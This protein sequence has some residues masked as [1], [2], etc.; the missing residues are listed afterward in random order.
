MGI[1]GVT[2]TAARL[3]V[4]GQVWL[5]EEK[6][7]RTAGRTLLT[8]FRVESQSPRV[9]EIIKAA[10]GSLQPELLRI[11]MIGERVEDIFDPFMEEWTGS[12]LITKCDRV[13]VIRRWDPNGNN[14]K[15]SYINNPDIPCTYPMCLCSQSGLFEFIILDCLKEGELGTFTMSITGAHNT[16]ALDTN[17]R[18][19]LKVLDQ[20]TGVPC[21][22]RRKVEEKS[23][24]GGGKVKVGIPYVQPAAGHVRQRLK[25]LSQN[26]LGTSLPEEVPGDMPALPNAGECPPVPQPPVP[27]PPASPPKVPSSPPPKAKARVKPKAKPQSTPKNPPPS[28]DE[29]IESE[30]ATQ[31][32][33]LDVP[34]TSAG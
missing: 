7:E 28:L 24:T 5:G 26:M 2:G 14:G 29:A 16:P 21:I 30:S 11:M 8:K 15:G 31:G 9:L 27:Q 17:L 18:G 4:I 1:H 19:I 20:F 34:A 3:P 22:L 23:K 10:Y 12:R 32:T 13:A 6:G 33:L 25:Q